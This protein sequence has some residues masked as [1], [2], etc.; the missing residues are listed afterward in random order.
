MIA[1]DRNTHIE[2]IEGHQLSVSEGAEAL[3]V[4]RPNLSAVLNERASLSLE[5]ALRCE[6]AFGL[7]MDTLIRLQCA[8]DA[9]QMR[10]R[11]YEVEMPPFVRRPKPGQTSL[12]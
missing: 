10:A 4:L 9:D 1:I 5:M 3:R 8:Y 7:S 12:M 2:I 6:K 11:A